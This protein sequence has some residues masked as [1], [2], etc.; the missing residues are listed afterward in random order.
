MSNYSNYNYNY[1]AAN[2][3]YHTYG[4]LLGTYKKYFDHDTSKSKDNKESMD[5]KK[6]AI[7][8]HR[9]GTG[10]NESNNFKCPNKCGSH[11]LTKDNQGKTNGQLDSTATNTAIIED[12]FSKLDND[13]IEETLSNYDLSIEI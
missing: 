6:Y 8:C 3:M 11:E 1:Y 4:S 13:E 7:I 12:Q 2:D 10:V 5:Q 9:C